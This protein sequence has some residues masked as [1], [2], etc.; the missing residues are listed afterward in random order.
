MPPTASNL[1]PPVDTRRQL[2]PVGALTWEDFER[3][4]LGLLE[5]ESD[6]VH[7][8]TPITRLYG[9]RGQAQFGIDVY[10][11]DPLVPGEVPPNRR[12]VSLQARRIKTVNEA[13]LTSAIDQFL[14]GR[15][16]DVSRQFIY[17]T[18]SSMASTRLTERIETEVRRL[19]QKSIE[20]VVWDQ[21]AISRRLK[22]QPRLVD[23]FFGRPWV[24]RFCG[25]EAARDL[26]T[27][28]DAQDVAKLRTELARTYAATFGV[29]DSG[30][31]A[32]RFSEASPLRLRDRFVTPD[33]V[34]TTPQAASLPY[35]ADD[36]ATDDRGSREPDTMLSEA[37]AWKEIAP[38]DGGWFP[39]TPAWEQRS[40]SDP[41]L[42]ERRPAD[43]WLGTE[44][45][46]VIVGEP[47]AGKSTLLRYLV[48][49]LL[50]ANPE[51]HT[52]AQRWGQR[53]PVWLPFHFFTQRV[54]GQTGAEASLSSA[55]QA[56]L[57]QHGANEVWPLVERALRDERLLLVV[58][59]LDEWIDEQAGRYAVAALESFAELRSAQLVAT[60]RPYGLT[61]FQLGVD[62]SYARIAPLTPEQQRKLALPY[63]RGV[64][65]HREDTS[66]DVI[67]RS[68]DRFFALVDE[69]S[70]LRLVSASPLF[71]TL[72]VGLHLSS[73]A[74]LPSGRFGV[75]EQAVQLL[76]ADHPA[77]RRVAAAVTSRQ[78]RLRD[79]QLRELLAR[80][81]FVTQARGDVSVVQEDALRRDIIG[82]LRDRDFLDMN[83]TEATDT[84][85][86]L[87]GVAE[88]E[89]GLLVRRG[90][91]ELGFLHRMLHEQ[92]AAE[93]A[94]DRLSLEQLK[95]LFADKVGDPRWR[96]VLLATIWRL[97]RPAELR[98]I[99]DV[100]R[101][102]I[103]HTL[104]GLR[105]REMLAEVTFGPYDLPVAEIQES[106]PE[107]IEAIETHPYSPHRARLLESV[108]SGLEGTDAGRIARDCLE[109]W[110]VLAEA[111]TAELVWQIAQVTSADGLS[112]RVHRL[113][114]RALRYPDASVAYA[115]AAGIA[116]RCSSG[117]SGAEGERDP[118]AQPTPPHPF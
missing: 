106:A 85:D 11:R 77:T 79:R 34:A 107:I 63:F 97:R 105:A 42:M 86:E 109:R 52:V 54:A 90:P 96:G 92:L 49:D 100:V 45:H 88:G 56:W 20:F 6:P 22:E 112:E 101:T 118:A 50:S 47:G 104:A 102:H 32:L 25:D 8:S 110:V 48:L 7:V 5:L 39:P 108:L 94:T 80:V 74:R 28:L 113:L 12:Y 15:W 1:P 64:T 99:V 87:L 40:A 43:Q 115:S 89:L 51:W 67:E 35:I 36:R 81:A 76:V 65:G 83:M 62:W 117:G 19:A 66:P 2:L 23:D 31:I 68:V 78:E 18:S 26:G 70:D 75:Y 16:A 93:Y 103:D 73:V 13:E 59:G 82:A 72:L 60:T 37:A 95:K 29:A 14:D 30:Q 44:A 114:I 27:R 61:H 33:L 3:L 98:S 57:D 41:Q 10:A 46:Q 58:D 111:P 84:A 17:A 55:L 91:A 9:R 69:A 38:D 4:C 116:G 53:L 24:A 71:L 21:E